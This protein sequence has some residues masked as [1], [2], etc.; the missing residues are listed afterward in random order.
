MQ[1]TADRAHLRCY[2]H[3]FDNSFGYIF[4]DTHQSYIRTLID[5]QLNAVIDGVAELAL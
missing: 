1:Y 3:N 5:E 4:S 2:V